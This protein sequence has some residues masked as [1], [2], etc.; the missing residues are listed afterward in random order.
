MK[1]LVS[2]HQDSY[3]LIIAYGGDTVNNRQKLDRLKKEN[4]KHSNTTKTVF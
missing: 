4:G 3:I 1:Y 2:P